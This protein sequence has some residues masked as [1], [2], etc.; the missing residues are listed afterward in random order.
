M[1]YDRIN[2]SEGIDINKSSRLK[3]CMLCYYW[4]FLDAS[5]RYEPEVCNGCLDISM[6]VYEL[7]SSAILNIMGV[8]CQCIRVM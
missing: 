5:Y 8:D 2:G 7:K 3:K 4:Y 6:M 1:Y